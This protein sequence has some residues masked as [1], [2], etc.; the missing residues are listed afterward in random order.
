MSRRI[1]QRI[2][3]RIRHSKAIHRKRKVD[4]LF[5]AK[6][7]DRQLTSFSNDLQIHLFCWKLF[8]QF[9]LYNIQ[10]LFRLAIMNCIFR[11]RHHSVAH[12]KKE[13]IVYLCRNTII[14]SS[15]QQNQELSD[16]AFT[17]QLGNF[18]SYELFNF[19]WNF[20]VSYYFAL[21]TQ[22]KLLT[23]DGN[24]FSYYG[25]ILA[26]ESFHYIRK[27]SLCHFKVNLKS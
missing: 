10:R 18:E 16:C 11:R 6:R 9:L 12:G 19:F 17:Q 24:F 25:F 7:T 1:S 2:K 15:P 20:F 3:I 8:L 14:C 13:K 27:I 4:N 5:S 22:L 23:N 21:E 26:K